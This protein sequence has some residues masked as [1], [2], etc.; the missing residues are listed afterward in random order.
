MTCV[1]PSVRDELI[2]LRQGAGG[3]AMRR[4]IED[5]LA[6]GFPAAPAGAIGLAEMDDGA[7]F[8]LGEGWLVLTTDSHVVH[9]IIFPGGDIGRL[10]IAGTVNDLA[11]MGATEPLG[12]T[13]AIVLEE[14]FRRDTLERIQRSMRDACVE[15]GTA[16]VTGD[17]K[18]MG[19]GELDGIVINTT[20]VGLA[21]QLVTDAG[22]RAGDRLLFTGS[23][24]DHGIAL[25]AKRHELGLDGELRSDVA[26]INGLIR[27]VLAAA[28]AELV[29]MKDPTR[30]GAASALHEM[31]GKSRVGIVIHEPA[32]AISPVVRAA[33][34]MLGLDPFHIA[35]EG[36][37]ILGVRPGAADRV[38]AALR[39]HPQGRDAALVGECIAEHTGRVILDTG[40]GRRLMAEPDGEP[41]PR[42][43]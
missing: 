41:L 22:L 19:R 39:A 12:L 31:A 13:S 24:G 17:T 2:T 23:I 14:G 21:R 42:I 43:C 40:L 27:A 30:G 29:A 36:K 3:R 26:P 25:M 32:V 6:A 37:A 7:A 16:V 33:A 9:P 18:V 1:L 8:P 34:E 20:G 4:L 11:M 10:A 35:N 38:L 15:A 5:C 28:G